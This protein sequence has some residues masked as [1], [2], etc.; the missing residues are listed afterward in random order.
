MS[1]LPV[2]DHGSAP[3][4]G[5]LHNGRLKVALLLAAV[6]GLLV[7]VGVLEAWI[8]IVLAILALVVYFGWARERQQATM[9]DAAW[10]VAVWQ[11]IVLLVPVLVV[12]VGTLALVAVGAIA[13]LALV[14]LFADRR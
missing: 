10:V 12:I 4:S 2:I 6:E 5:R 3:E 14:A 7:A 11:A 13:V 1:E 9:R 8:A